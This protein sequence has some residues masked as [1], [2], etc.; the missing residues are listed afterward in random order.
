MDRHLLGK[1]PTVG[2]PRR[3]VRRCF[4][5]SSVLQER[6]QWP[7][8][9]GSYYPAQGFFQPLPA[10]P[11]G[12]RRV[13]PVGRPSLVLTRLSALAS[14]QFWVAITV[15]IRRLRSLP[16]S[17]SPGSGRIPGDAERILP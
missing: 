14:E 4:R 17:P 15:V 12:N 7:P 2:Q 1:F 11:W 6:R 5:V 10:R 3:V 8:T 16:G 9:S 13:P